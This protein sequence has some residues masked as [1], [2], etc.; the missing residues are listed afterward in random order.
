MHKD[1]HYG[2]IIYSCIIT[3]CEIAC[4]KS[5]ATSL[6]LLLA[7][8]RKVSSKLL[9]SPHWIQDSSCWRLKM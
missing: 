5:I 4:V 8:A 2:L 7:D 1:H 3:A 6:C 9:A